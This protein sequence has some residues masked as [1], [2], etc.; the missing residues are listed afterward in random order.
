M[1]SGG[2]TEQRLPSDGFQYFFNRYLVFI[3]FENENAVIFKYSKAFINSFFYHPW[4]IFGKFTILL[5]QPTFFTH[6]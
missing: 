3:P 6:I 2:V 5:G 4:P 1:S